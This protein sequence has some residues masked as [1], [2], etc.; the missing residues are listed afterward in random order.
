MDAKPVAGKRGKKSRRITLDDVAAAAGVSLST[1]SRALAGEKGVRL[2]IREKVLA[3][4]KQVN[5][6]VSA[7]LAGSQVI[8]AASSAAM[9][10]YVRNQF[11]LY[12]LEGLKD[13]AATLGL[14]VVQRAVADT[15][16]EKQ[17]LEEARNDPAVSGL[18]FLTVDD[19][20]MLA[21]TRDFSKPVILLNGHDPSMRLSSVT[22]SN[23][24]AARVAAEHL[25]GLGHRRILFLMRPGRRTIVH[26]MEGWQ[27]A[28]KARG[29]Q[30]DDD[31]VVTV[32]DWLPELAA[33]AIA[34]RI[35]ERGQDF[36]AILTAGDS[37][38]LGAI[39]GVQRTGLSVP[40][41]VSVVG[42][43]DLPQAAFF[44]P[45]LTTMH[46]PMREIGAVGLD[47][48]RD[49]AAG[50]VYPARRVELA[51]HLIERSSTAPPKD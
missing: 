47:L 7:N 22:P 42:M 21:A 26:R 6:T 46:L 50:M 24:S 20:A 29:L 19:E 35:S 36:T 12:V 44:N 4:A 15:Q 30:V 3:A 28:L 14:D 32:D 33:D 18:L 31:L 38:A 49:A 45:P 1:A 17:L 2:E 48:L 23:R 16:D 40:G 13:R 11:T 39:L 5:Y 27:D 43:D 9:L 8:L 51:C 34:K 41:D 25:I 37:L 10:D